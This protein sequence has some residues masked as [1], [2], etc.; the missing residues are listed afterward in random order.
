VALFVELFPDD[1]E[2]LGVVCDPSCF[3]LVD[4]ERLA[5][6]AINVWGSL[7]GR[8]VGLCPCVFVDFHDLGVG[9]GRREVGPGARGKRFVGVP[10]P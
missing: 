2:R 6:E 4:Q 3:R 1:D 7:V 9:Q 5:D 10:S 8:R